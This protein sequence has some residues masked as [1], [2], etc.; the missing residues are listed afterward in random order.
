M[1]S[2]AP[3]NF[4]NNRRTPQLLSSKFL[5][6]KI[7]KSN[8]YVTRRSFPFE[9]LKLPLSTPLG[10]PEGRQF[11]HWI[12]ILLF[13]DQRFFFSRD[14]LPVDLF[15]TPG[16]YSSQNKKANTTFISLHLIIEEKHGR[17]HGPG[18]L[19]ILIIHEKHKLRGTSS[20]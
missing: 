17:C 6:S 20:Y 13:F 8:P 14:I 5:V 11:S 3:C 16:M 18:F 2:G 12:H 4:F 9:I 7:R 1:L 19:Y 15:V 10:G